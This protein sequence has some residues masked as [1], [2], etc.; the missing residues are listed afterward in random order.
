MKVWGL[1]FYGPVYAGTAASRSQGQPARGH[2]ASMVSF[3]PA[4]LVERGVRIEARPFPG[5]M[6][7][8]RT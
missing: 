3:G 1:I 8:D 5:E 2:A 6:I 4:Y 7:A